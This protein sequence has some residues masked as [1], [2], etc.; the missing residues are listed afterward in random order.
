M[1]G[2]IVLLNSTILKER[3]FDT[4][5]E[6]LAGVNALVGDHDDWSIGETSGG[7]GDTGQRIAFGQGPIDLTVLSQLDKAGQAPPGTVRN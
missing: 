6:A 1:S 3:R 4:L 7:E 5:E 2:R